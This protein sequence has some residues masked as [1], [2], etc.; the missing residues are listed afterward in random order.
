MITDAREY[1]RRLRSPLMDH[2]LNNANVIREAQ[3]EVLEHIREVF[4][5]GLVDENATP[6]SDTLA[7]RKSLESS[8]E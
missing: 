5:K 7:L 8:M 2:E 6:Y 4:G 1:A 3:L